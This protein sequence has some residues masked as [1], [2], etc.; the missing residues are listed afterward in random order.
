LEQPGL[1]PDPA[2]TEEGH[3][4]PETA[5]VRITQKPGVFVDLHLPRT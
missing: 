1:A 2:T 3:G 4:S 5:D